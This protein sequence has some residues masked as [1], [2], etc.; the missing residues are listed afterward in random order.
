VFKTTGQV[1]ALTLCV[2]CRGE[3]FR[4]A[5]PTP[6]SAAVKERVDLYIV[7]HSGP[8]WPFIEWTL[9]V[10]MISRDICHCSTL[11][12]CS[13]WDTLLLAHRAFYGVNFTRSYDIQGYLP[14][15]HSYILQSLRHS[16]ISSQFHRIVT[17]YLEKFCNDSLIDEALLL[18]RD[19]FLWTKVEAAMP[20]ME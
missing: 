18:L 13:L 19:N 1:F 2:G 6:S 14:L 8:S 3:G 9:H 7:S 11:T 10:V 16:V 12:H 5:Q 4:G 20:T 17:S 15:L